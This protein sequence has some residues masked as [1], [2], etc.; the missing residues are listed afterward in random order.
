MTLYHKRKVSFM[1]PMVLLFGFAI[2]KFTYG[3]NSEDI[4]QGCMS[5][6]NKLGKGVSQYL[7]ITNL[8]TKDAQRAYLSSN[9][10][11]LVVLL[12]LA[13][14]IETNPCPIKALLRLL[15]KNTAKLRRNGSNVKTVKSNFTYNV[16]KLMRTNCWS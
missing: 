2:W 13:G 10:T 4:N 14:D 9:R 15:K 8:G 11:N 12:I 3:S 16:L 1:F 6:V 7:A 5:K